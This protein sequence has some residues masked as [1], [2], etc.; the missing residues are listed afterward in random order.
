MRFRKTRNL[1]MLLTFRLQN[2]NGLKSCPKNTEDVTGQL[3]RLA[4]TMY[5]PPTRHAT[6]TRHILTGRE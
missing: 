1:V 6:W 2:S 4:H 5:R 3:T